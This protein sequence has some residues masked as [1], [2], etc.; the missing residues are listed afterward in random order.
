MKE[1][2][3]IVSVAQWLSLCKVASRSRTQAWSTPTMNKHSLI[4]SLICCV[5]PSQHSHFQI[6]SIYNKV[7]G[8]SKYRNK[9]ISK[10]FLIHSQKKKNYYCRT[11]Q[12]IRTSEYTKHKST[13]IHYLRKWIFEYTYV[14]WYCNEYC[15]S[16]LPSANPLIVQITHSSRFNWAWIIIK[17]RQLRSY[18]G[19]VKYNGEG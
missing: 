7:N 4:Q 17:A 2:D 3:E 15:H 14:C 13:Y 18:S 12:L 19:T 8:L 1:W 10:Y 5:F 9:L 11:K 6:I 16:I